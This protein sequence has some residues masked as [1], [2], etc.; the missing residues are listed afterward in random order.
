VKRCKSIGRL[1][2]SAFSLLVGGRLSTWE[3]KKIVGVVGTIQ[4]QVEIFFSFLVVVDS[5]LDQK[6]KLGRV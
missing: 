4:G 3:E 1:W 5:P 6:S 2:V